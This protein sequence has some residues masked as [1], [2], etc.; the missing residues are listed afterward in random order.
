MRRQIDR[1]EKKRMG[2]YHVLVVFTKHVSFWDW[3]TSLFGRKP[4]E[5][6]QKHVYVSKDGLDWQDMPPFRNVSRRK[7]KELAGLF[8][9]DGARK[10]GDN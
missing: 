9:G 10:A 5:L 1:V 3:A 4:D 7:S 2:D 6:I 8:D